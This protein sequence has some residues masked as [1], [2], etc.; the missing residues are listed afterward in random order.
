M[1]ALLDALE[2]EWWATS[3]PF[4]DF[5]IASLSAYSV[6]CFCRSFHGPEVFLTDLFGLWKYVIT[7]HQSDELPYVIIPLSGWMKNEIGEKFHLTPLC[8][9][10]TSGLAVETWVK[11]LIQTHE[12]FSRT[13]GPAFCTPSGI[14]A[15]IK[16]YELDILDR[17]QTIQ[18]QPPDLISVDVN[19]LEE[20]G[21]SRSFRRG[22]MSEA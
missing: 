7:P 18:A 3:D 12:H 21:L 4:H 9:K 6:I 22:S 17:L 20:Y 19:V 5:H 14:A 16:T 13:R 15:S 1:H 2:T 10:T 8:A 11:H